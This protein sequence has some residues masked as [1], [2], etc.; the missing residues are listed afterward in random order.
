MSEKKQKQPET[1]I[2]I[3]EKSDTSQL[4]KFTVE[5]VLKEYLK[6]LNIWQSYGGGWK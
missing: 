6:P 2:M 3:N 4:Y 5:Y 1:H